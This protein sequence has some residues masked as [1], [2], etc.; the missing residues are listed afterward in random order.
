MENDK[1]VCKIVEYLKIGYYDYKIKELLL[2]ENISDDKFEQLLE[3]AKQVVHQEKLKN[4]EKRNKM[5][6]ILF[7][8][9]IALSFLAFLF[10]IPNLVEAPSTFFPILGAALICL[11]S[12]LAIAY[13]K[14]WNP[15]FV[16]EHETPNINYSFLFLM[17][18]P[19]MIF[20]FI[21]S[22]RFEA[23]ADNLLKENQIEVVGEI[24]SGGETEIQNRRGSIK[25]STVAVEFQT[26]EGKKIIAYENLDT[27]EFK[28]FHIN[29]KVNMI[30]SKSN[31]Q[32]ISLL[33][34]DSDLSKFKNS[35]EKEI[36]PSDL[37]HLMSIDKNNITTE[38]NKLSYGWEYNDQQ[39]LWVNNRKNMAISVTQDSVSYIGQNGRTA[40][41]FLKKNGFKRINNS[42]TS[43]LSAFDLNKSYEN[44]K[45]KAS[46]RSV[47]TGNGQEPAAI[48]T[49]AKK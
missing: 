12:Y 18:I 38:L 26:L 34:S 10:L 11:F 8:A 44:D 28:S 9:G 14:T 4:L 3:E 33:M 5:F 17:L 39:M 6:F 19:A 29:Q 21:L 48:T 47:N 43:S 31:P 49:I 13:Y 15:E 7:A 40:D 27:Y 1:L 45:Y 25:I 35:K 20:Y 2:N 36:L 30:Y 23:V 41:H 46:V 37:I 42:S 32:N 24:V 16:K 22:L